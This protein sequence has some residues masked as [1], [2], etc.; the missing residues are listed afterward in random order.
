LK[1]TDSKVDFEA[2]RCTELPELYEEDDDNMRWRHGDTSESNWGSSG[3]FG[4]GKHGRHQSYGA[5]FG[6]NGFQ[7]HGPRSNGGGYGGKP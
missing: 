4:G 5:G 6:S 7:K 3:A 2:V 1:E